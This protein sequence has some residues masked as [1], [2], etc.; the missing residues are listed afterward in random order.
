MASPVGAGADS[1]DDE[2]SQSEKSENTTHQQSDLPSDSDSEDKASKSQSNSADDDDS[3][4]DMAREERTYGNKSTRKSPKPK[5]GT[6]TCGSCPATGARSDRDHRQSHVV[7]CAC[8][9]GLR[10]LSEVC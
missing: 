5:E 10:M 1:K 7:C 4:D 6:V 9:S 3:S 8:I 2:S